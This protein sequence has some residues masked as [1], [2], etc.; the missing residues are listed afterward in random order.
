MKLSPTL[1]AG[2][3]L[4]LAIGFGIALASRPKSENGTA[5][6][7]E[8][9]PVDRTKPQKVVASRSSP[10]KPS[11]DSAATCRKAWEL[12][13]TLPPDERLRLR[14]RLLQ[15]WASVD[16]ASAM[17]AVLMDPE[18][19]DLLVSLEGLLAENPESFR[20]LFAEER[21]GLKTA[22][23][24]QWW[25]D[26]MAKIRPELL[27]SSIESLGPYDQRRSIA[28]LSKTVSDPEK[29]WDLLNPLTALPDNERNRRLWMNLSEAV[30]ARMN[31]AAVVDWCSSV[32]GPA[33]QVM[34]THSMAVLLGRSD[35]NGAKATYAALSPELRQQIV[36]AAIGKPGSNADAYRAAIDEVINTPQWASQAK[37]IGFNLHNMSMSQS[38][39]KSS[40]DWALKLPER[41]DT[42]DIYRVAIRSYLTNKP[43]EART[44]IEALP[45]GW[46]RQNSLAAYV[47]TTMN[48]RKDPDDAMWAM[49]QISDPVFKKE[50]EGYFLKYEETTGKKV[51]R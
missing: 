7:A 12:L 42:M 51:P 13:R 20:E 34:L 25:I 43:Q 17:E 46:K 1:V 49:R 37:M 48:F 11:P 14:G 33:G 10:S 23:L 3:L 29:L 31:A 30:A 5:A 35:Y 19:K 4:A 32:P 9:S 40:L 15:E 24:R 16:L 28:A 27:L 41:D 36:Q 38:I 8:A 21:Y 45:P 47:Q 44:W 6:V 2:H 18:A 50:A 39:Q 22:V 26:Q